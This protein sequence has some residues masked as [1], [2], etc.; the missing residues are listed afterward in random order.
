MFRQVIALAVGGMN[1]TQT[2]E[3]QSTYPGISATPAP[4]AVTRKVKLLPV[5][6]ASGQHI[7][8]GDIARVY[9]EDGPPG[10]KSENSRINGWSFI[11]NQGV[12]VGT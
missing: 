10:I 7:A 12:D 1:V 5:I 6:A 8:L 2:V 3:G 4:S 11:D 9:I